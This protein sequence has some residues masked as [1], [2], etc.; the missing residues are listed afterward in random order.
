MSCTAFGIDFCVM[1]WQL[2]KMQSRND[3]VKYCCHECDAS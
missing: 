3:L 1:G 2:S